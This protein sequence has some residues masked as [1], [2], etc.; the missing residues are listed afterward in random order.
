[1]YDDFE[2]MYAYMIWLIDV[3]RYVGI[4]KEP[5]SSTTTA[6][7]I[8][9]IDSHTGTLTTYGPL[10]FQAICNTHLQLRKR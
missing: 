1:M 5:V 7:S 2:E 9:C 6:Q 4:G 8:W 3:R 10:H